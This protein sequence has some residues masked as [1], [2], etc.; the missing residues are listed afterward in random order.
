MSEV[1]TT[2]E[3]PQPRQRGAATDGRPYVMVLAVA[4]WASM[5]RPNE[6]VADQPLP[7]AN[8]RQAR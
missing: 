1:A 7:E 2:I 5:P 4:P 8:A 3:S 6:T